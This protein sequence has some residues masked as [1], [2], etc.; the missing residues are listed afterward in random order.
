MADET[1]GDYYTSYNAE[2]GT[3]TGY[4]E[5]EKINDEAYQPM[6]TAHKS[7]FL[8]FV[9]NTHHD[10]DRGGR[11]TGNREQTVLT[12]QL[13]ILYYYKASQKFS[14]NEKDTWNAIDAAKKQLYDFS[15]GRGDVMFINSIVKENFE[16]DFKLITITGTIMYNWSMEVT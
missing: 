12:F 6:P 10:P 8:E 4:A 1:F 11:M 14:E 15:G 13:K 3:W 2:V 9:E 7:F 5:N 16:S